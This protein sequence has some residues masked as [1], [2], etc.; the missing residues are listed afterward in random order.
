VADDNVFE[1]GATTT[2]HYGAPGS[3]GVTIAETNFAAAWNVQAGA[4][5]P[6]VST[7]ARALFGLSLPTV[8]NTTSREG[9]LTALWI[10]PT[11]WLLV[12]TD[13]SPLV[14]F[15]TKRDALNAAGGALFDVSA[16]RVGWTIAGPQ[17]AA[18]L[19]KG[20]PLDFDARVFRDGMCAQSVFGRVNALFYRRSR[21]PGEPADQSLQRFTMLVARSFARDTWRFLCVS[22]AQYGYEVLHPQPF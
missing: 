11:S 9:A 6:A 21:L 10:G 8:P 14:H 5:S 22:A 4:R 16:G 7:A 2:G 13:V 3:T 19:A 15:E 17:A 12:A 18:V 1:V 20:C